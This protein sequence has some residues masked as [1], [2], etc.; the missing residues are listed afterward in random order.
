MKLV[1]TAICAILISSSF[2]YARNFENDYSSNFTLE[3]VT[4]ISEL[5]F[6]ILD[7]TINVDKI[8]GFADGQYQ[9]DEWE[10]EQIDTN[11]F[12]IKLI[13]LKK[14]GVISYLH[15]EV[16]SIFYDE[17][18]LWIKH[19]DKIYKYGRGLQPYN[20][21]HYQRVSQEV[22]EVLIDTMKLKFKLL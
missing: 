5:K 1:I 11:V 10:I 6:E 20:E 7:G 17:L 19:K 4:S 15:T 2:L 16:I 3:E 14:K 22:K 8:G 18:K 12:T 13:F 21:T 9:L